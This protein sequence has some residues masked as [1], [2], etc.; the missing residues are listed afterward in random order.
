VLGEHRICN[1]VE[2]A[3]TP[4]ALH[5]VVAWNR[6][7]SDPQRYT[8]LDHV[9]AAESINVSYFEPP[10]NIRFTNISTGPAHSSGPE[11][12]DEEQTRSGSN[13]GVRR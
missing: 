5:H 11:E 6:H 1:Y 12:D 13:R 4:A 8:R 10:Q 3:G 2:Q 9:S 7:V